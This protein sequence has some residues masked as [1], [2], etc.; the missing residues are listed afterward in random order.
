M[1]HSAPPILA[2]AATP[3]TR[4]M[5]GLVGAVILVGALPGCMIV[6]VGVTNPVRGLRTVAVV[7]FFNQSDER[8]VDGRLMA[9]Q[10]ASELQ[11]TPGL[12][13]IPAGVVETTMRRYGLTSLSGPRQAAQLAM[14]LNADAVVVGTVTEFSPYYP[15]RIGLSVAWYSPYGFQFDPGMPTDPAA[16][17]RIKDDL[18]A[19]RKARFNHHKQRII[20]GVEGRLDRFFLTESAHPTQ[21]QNGNSLQTDSVPPAP[22]VPD[23]SKAQPLDLTPVASPP[24]SGDETRFVP[25]VIFRGQSPAAEPRP[26]TPQSPRPMNGKSASPRTVARRPIAPAQ[27]RAIRPIMSY[28]RVFDASDQETSAAFRD[29]LEWRDD[30][31]FA[32][33][34]AR[35]QWSDEFPRFVMRMMIVE[36]FQ[37]HG[38]EG[39]R[40]VVWKL[41]KHR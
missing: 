9:S 7:P 17:K 31:R 33:W 3:I 21:L 39:R 23:F 13:V 12:E 30:G 28:T 22:P 18:R 19:R 14:L 1:S 36:M 6:D 29:F 10:Y 5:A 25:P 41:R 35:L 11:K 38:G 27:P 16:R 2:K 8:A 26:F 40:R 32:D 15:P 20:K 34:T 24:P 4:R 37:L